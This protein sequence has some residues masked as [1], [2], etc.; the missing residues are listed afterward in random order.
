MAGERIFLDTWFIHAL[1]NARD[2][3]HAQAKALL[4]RVRSAAQVVSTE[5]IIIETCNG[6]AKYNRAGASAFVRACYADPR[7][8]IVPV[9]RR[10]LDVALEHFSNA[11]DKEWGL[12]DCISFAVMRELGLH[13]AATGDHH[14]RQAG[15]VSLLDAPPES[16]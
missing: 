11:A 9:S 16:R 1:L 10:L 15:F 5:A 7:F 8:E 4:P 6:L 14:F 13:L 3:Y 2:S 12:T